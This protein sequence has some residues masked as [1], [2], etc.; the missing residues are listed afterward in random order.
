[1]KKIILSFFLLL[2]FTFNLNA[3]WTVQTSGVTTILRSVSVVDQN[4]AFISGD[5]G[6]VLKT[7]NG[8]TTW[9]NIAAS[10]IPTTFGCDVVRAIDANTVIVAGSPADTY[11]Y[12]TTNSGVTWTQVFTQVG[13]YVDDIQ[14]KDATNGIMYGDPVGSRWSIWKTTNAG[15]TWDSTGMYLPQAA[16]EAGWD[17]AMCVR[18]NNVWFGTNTAH[19][20]RSTNFGTNWI[21]TNTTGLTQ[22]TSITFSGNNGFVTGSGVTLK[23]T[24]AGVTWAAFTNPGTGTNVHLQSL[25]TRFWIAQ[26]NIYASTDNGATFPLS[27]T[28]SATTGPMWN[29]GANITG[30]SLTVYVT[31]YAGGIWKYTE[32]LPVTLS[33]AEQVSP[34]TT[35]L[36]SV[37]APND[38]IAWAC[39]VSGKVV[40]TTN[41]GATWT[42]V[43]GT[44]STTYSLVNI[45]ALDANTCLVTGYAGANTIIY[46]TTDGGATWTAVYGPVAGFVDDLYMTDANNAYYIGDPVGGS[47][48]LKKST[49]GGVNWT[50][51]STLTTSNTSGTYNNAA[52]FLGT[53]VWFSGNGDNSINYSTNMGVNWTSQPNAQAELGAIWFNSATNGMIGGFTTSLGVK[54]TTNSGTIWTSVTNP[55]TVALIAITGSGNEYWAGSQGLNI[56]YSSNSG[57]NWTTSYT[58]SA[59]NFNAMQKARSG[60]TIWG[61]RANGGISRYGTPL[62]GVTPIS[63]EIPSSYSVSQNYPNPFNPTTKINFALPKSGL[64]TLK[65][66]NMLGKEV[67]TLVNEVKNV[68]TYSVDFNGA[69]LSSGIYFYK[70]NVNGF[71]EVKKMMLIK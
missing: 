71:S 58:V 49:N 40:R 26:T 55:A 47:W 42:N 62:V 33:W 3:Q 17:N 52:C 53:N 43:S 51:W 60:N 37:S 10:P 25:G 15:T 61:V 20:Y 11:I 66:Y 6:K 9:T 13:G 2:I 59:G 24:D 16:A 4:V 45:F 30:S 38:D 12:K 32:T 1:M 41:K 36:Q 57:T 18:G 14:F 48:D 64:V 29:V 31:G 39:G 56:Y 35:S 70:V 67:A 69:N 27:Y 54:F 68:G 21:S 28:Y 50:T 65:V 5:A 8:G 7:T 44:I 46:R 23:S 19:I 22:S 34:L 63:L